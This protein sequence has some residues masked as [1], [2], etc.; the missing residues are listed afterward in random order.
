MRIN[1]NILNRRASRKEFFYVLAQVG[2]IEEAIEHGQAQRVHKI[3]DDID[4][5]LVFDSSHSSGLIR[6]CA[7]ISI[8]IH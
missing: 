2:K 8:G 3:I 6:N 4:T 7:K 5:T 1:K